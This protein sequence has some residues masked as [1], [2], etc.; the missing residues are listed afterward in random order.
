ML[1]DCF[2]SGMGVIPF[3]GAGLSAEFD[4][5]QWAELLTTLASVK[6]KPAVQRLV[7]AGRYEKAAQK[8]YEGGRAADRLQAGIMA[9]FK[10]TF[11]ANAFEGSAVSLLPQLT[12]GPVVT[13]NFDQVLE[14]V[15]ER[16]KRPFKGRPILGSDPD[17]FVPAIQRNEHVLFKIHGDCENRRSL[18]LTLDSY[19]D[20]YGRTRTQQGPREPPRDAATAARE[21]PRSLPRL[22]SHERSHARRRER[23]PRSPRRHLALRRRR[24]AVQ[25]Q[26]VRQTPRASSLRWGSSRFGFRRGSSGASGIVSGICSRTSRSRP[27]TRRPH[28]H[29]VRPAMLTRSSAR[30]RAPTPVREDPPSPAEP[31]P[32]QEI[33]TELVDAVKAVRT[34]RVVFFLGAGAAS[35]LLGNE[36]YKQLAKSHGVPEFG[37]ARADAAQ[38]IV[39]LRKR[40][41]LVAGIRK[42][43]SRRVCRPS[44]T[45]RFLARLGKCLSAVLLPRVAAPA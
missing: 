27:F 45:H 31:P 4:F 32:N 13:T 8:L 42:E 44:R 38:H 22:Q 10:R 9:T 20:S 30:R 18:T 26:G 21:S 11:P 39:D 6:S 28:P 23:R 7:T 15:F 19:A 5:P 14:R 37:R 34:G 40:S 35:G 36:F 33:P 1:I 2:S 12:C 43:F 24:S 3:V 29:R 17:A 16:A 41:T 25:R